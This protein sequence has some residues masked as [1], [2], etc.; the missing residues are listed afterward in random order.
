MKGLLGNK[1]GLSM[2][3][4]I[5]LSLACKKESS[6][7]D[8]IILGDDLGMF[9]NDEE[10]LIYTDFEDEDSLDLNQDGVYDL[11]FKSISVP[12]T[13]GYTAIPAMVPKAN[14]WLKVDGN[15]IQSSPFRSVIGLTDTWHDSNG[16]AVVW[17]DTPDEM[18]ADKITGQFYLAFLL[19][20]E[21]LGWVEMRLDEENGAYAP[22]VN[23]FR[24]AKR[25]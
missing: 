5:L 13:S 24:I 16:R 10:V 11:I 2:L 4:L 9:T 7:P 23:G 8:E 20:G 25:N 14:L 18:N 6:F 15:Q 22:V 21:Q 19:N 3:C 1:I 12:G 17:P